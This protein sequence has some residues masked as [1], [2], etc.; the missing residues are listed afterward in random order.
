MCLRI[1]LSIQHLSSVEPYLIGEMV[2]RQTRNGT[3]LKCIKRQAWISMIIILCYIASSIKIVYD[4]PV[5]ML[6]ESDFSIYT[7][8]SNQRKDTKKYHQTGFNHANK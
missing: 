1:K 8:K 5:Y 3:I 7:K 2:I 6:K 4:I